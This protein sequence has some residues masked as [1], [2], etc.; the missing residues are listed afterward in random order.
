MGPTWFAKGI[1]I[2][3]GDSGGIERGEYKR[4]WSRIANKEKGTKQSADSN[5]KESLNFDSIY[6]EGGCLKLRKLSNAK[7]RDQ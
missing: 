2:E 5:G 7:D 4:F 6:V 3:H 1:V